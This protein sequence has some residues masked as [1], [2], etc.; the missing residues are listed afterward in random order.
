[1]AE[2]PIIDDLGEA[3]DDA[4]A[5]AEAEEARA[6]AS[7]R[8]G[9][10]LP[11]GRRTAPAVGGA[12]PR[13]SLALA[14]LLLV[15]LGATAAGGTV[16]VLRGTVIPAPDPDVAGPAQTPAP[17]TSRLADARAGDPTPGTRWALRVARSRTGLVCGTV[18]E[19]RGER[20]GLTGLDGRFRVLPER[21][22]D[23]CSAPRPKGPTLLGVRV[24]DARAPE[25]VRTVLYGLADGLASVE[26]ASTRGRTARVPVAD[27]GSFAAAYAGHP[28]DIGLRVTLRF[29]DGRVEEHPLG[30]EAGVTPDPDGGRAWRAQSMMFGVAPGDTPDPRTC[31]DFR[32]ARPG[33]PPVT[34]PSACGV[35]RGTRER[36]G[37]FFA[38]RRIA[39]GTGGIP[40]QPGGEGNWGK[41]PARTAVWGAA[42]NDVRRVEVL[43]A[44]GRGTP[45][46]LAR[47]RAF[48][49]VFPAAVDPAGLRV[50]VTKADGAVR[51]YTGSTN[52]VSGR[53]K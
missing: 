4:F 11:R 18:G 34:S 48:V 45:V 26:A 38:V 50:R 39:P 8:R 35:L 40:F 17:G 19:V 41:H 16:A 15:L 30:T 21:L 13:R 52:L 14:S 10:L 36:R 47:S 3:L 23:A 32:T 22:V 29:R 9:R 46:P 24:L 37:V 27:D 43:G 2:L 7:R 44:G 49:A 6:A 28:E 20:F 25:D 51:T 42:G 12:L 31:V 33:G 53:R 1:M 5:R